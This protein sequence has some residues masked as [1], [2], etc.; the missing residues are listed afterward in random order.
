M[1]Q[2]SIEW[3]TKV[4]NPTTMYLFGRVKTKKIKPNPRPMNEDEK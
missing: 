2:S 3:T 1:A 4:W